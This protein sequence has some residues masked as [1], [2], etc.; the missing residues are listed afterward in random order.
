MDIKSLFFPIGG[1]DELKER[2]R[3]ALITNKFF[4]AHLEILECEFDM[5]D[6][7][8][9]GLTLRSDKIFPKFLKSCSDDIND[10]HS[11]CTKIFDDVCKEL[12]VKIEKNLDVKNGANLIL[13][14]GIRSKI[15]EN[16]SRYFDAIIVAVPPKGEITGTFEAVVYKSGKPSII[17]PRTMSSFSGDKILVALNGTKTSARALSNW[18]F[19]LKNAKSVHIVASTHYLENSHE[20]T[21]EKIINY[22]KLHN[23]NPTF[24]VVETKGKIPGEI[25]LEKSANFDLIV[26]GIEEDK[27]FKGTFLIGN[28]KY[29]LKNTKIPVLM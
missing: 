15:V 19:M 18:L 24:E 5:V 12:G 29:F 26:A 9:V 2:I 14:K 20:E 4:N 25:L 23:I 3:G 17:I 21:K 1:G 11:N 8:N 10:L 16:Y 7:R 27:G 13:K 22:L 28:S 6:A